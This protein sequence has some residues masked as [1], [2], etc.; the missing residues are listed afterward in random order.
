MSI[1]SA[2][3]KVYD[4]VSIPENFP[5]WATAFCLSFQKSIE[6]NKWIIDTP[7]GQA[8][9]RFAEKNKFGIV[10]H[11]VSPSPNFE[12][13]IP[14]RIVTNNLGSEVMFTIFRLPNMSDDQ[15]AKAIDLVEKD[16]NNLKQIMEN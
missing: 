4:F 9:I 15:M 16:L 13:Y 2:A 1:N 12:I 11:F 14:M 10:D 7:N 6:E 8:T 3:E 5:K